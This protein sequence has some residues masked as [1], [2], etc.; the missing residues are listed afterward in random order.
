MKV[1]AFDDVEFPRSR[2]RDER[3]HLGALVAAV[4]DEAFDERKP[5]ASLAKQR[6]RTIAI[7]N[8]GSM[9]VDVQQQAERVDQDVALAAED[10]LTRVETLAIDRPPPFN[11]PL[12]LCASMIAT[13]GLASR[14]A[15]PRLS[16]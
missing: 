2:T 12:A 11:A 16:T 3:A 13:V 5:L 9:D 10:F 4:G 15:C 8:V 1:G 14:P 6:F 7:L